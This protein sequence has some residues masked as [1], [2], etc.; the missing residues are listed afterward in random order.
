MKEIGFKLTSGSYTRRN[1]FFVFSD[2]FS[3]TAKKFGHSWTRVQIWKRSI[4]Y[5]YT[6][7]RNHPFLTPHG[8]FCSPSSC[9]I[10]ETGRRCRK[11]LV[12]FMIW[13]SALE[14][15]MKTRILNCSQFWMMETSICVERYWSYDDKWYNQS[16]INKKYD[17][18]RIV[19][20]DHDIG[21]KQSDID[22]L[23]SL[24]SCISWYFLIWSLVGSY[25]SDVPV[26]HRFTTNQ[27]GAGFV[28]L[29]VRR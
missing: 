4:V 2:A 24:S 15:T 16:A 1:E 26:N 28:S 20:Q 12:F 14:R 27:F 10:C 25:S 18:Y 9:F 21:N 19:Y 29:V 7:Q 11:L 13:M 6:L 17:H 23:V 3:G 22:S 5:L 8:C